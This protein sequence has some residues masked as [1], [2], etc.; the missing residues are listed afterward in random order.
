MSGLQDRKANVNGDTVNPFDGPFT[1]AGVVKS[2][3]DD[4]CLDPA[5]IIGQS[6]TREHVIARAIVIHFC[7]ESG[8]AYTAIARRLGGRD[9]STIIYAYRMLF[10]HLANHQRYRACYQRHLI[11]FA[12]RGKPPPNQDAHVQAWTAREVRRFPK[13]PA[14]KPARE[15]EDDEDALLRFG[16]SQALSEAIAA[17]GGWR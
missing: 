6:R 13:A 12:N 17:A 16:G 5:R 2:V 4:L 1:V 3:A 9:H 15:I 8:M 11:M 7:R 14:P 10:T